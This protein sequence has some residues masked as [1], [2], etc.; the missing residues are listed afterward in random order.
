MRWNHWQQRVTYNYKGNEFIV[1]VQME[2]HH[3]DHTINCKVGEQV[4]IDMF[5]WYSNTPIN[6]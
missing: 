2:N 4:A 1:T 6:A 5:Q 3:D